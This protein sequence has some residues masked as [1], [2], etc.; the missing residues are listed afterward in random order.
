[1]FRKALEESFSQKSGAHL[2]PPWTSHPRHYPRTQESTF[3]QSI[4]SLTAEQDTEACI[5]G[6]PWTQLDRSFFH[7][8][9]THSPENGSSLPPLFS[10]S[11]HPSVCQM[12]HSPSICRENWGQLNKRSRI[13]PEH[14][15]WKPPGLS[16]QPQRWV[17]PFQG[18]PLCL[19]SFSDIWEN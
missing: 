7:V 4:Q 11:Q 2:S 18:L 6:P 9:L 1:M 14:L 16:P 12:T 8:I 15:I 10:G 17:P 5:P 19:E 3:S 13:W